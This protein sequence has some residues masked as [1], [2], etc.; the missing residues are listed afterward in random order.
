MSFKK[1][2][3]EIK[4]IKDFKPSQEINSLFDDL[5][6]RV[7]DKKKRNNLSLKQ[8]T[9]LQKICSQSEYELEKFWSK[10]IIS[11]QK[12]IL[13][14]PY[15]QNYQDLTRLELNTINSCVCH[16]KH[17][18]LFIGGG[19]FPMTSIILAQE[20]NIK[21]VILDNDEEAV[22]ISKKLLCFLGLQKMISV[23][24]VD[25]QSFKNYKDF[26][27]I[28]V[29][30]LAGSKISEK[31]NIFYTIKNSSQKDAHILARSSW[32]KRKILYRPISKKIYSIF[33]PILEIHPHNKIINSVI[34]LKNEYK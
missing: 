33:K 9:S 10:N 25:A 16:S 27:V 26:N 18:I 5:V 21:S 22:K 1:I 34:L 29:A 15:Y 31:N 12:N 19:P 20:Y 24:Y 17:K 30:A 32:G 7:I 13:D 14:F 8:C 4:K 23:K 11:G 2:Y 6:M 3:S 28:F